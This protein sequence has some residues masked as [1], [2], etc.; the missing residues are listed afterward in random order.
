MLLAIETA[1]DVCS[2]A[3]LEGG[4]LVGVA[5]V[6]RPRSHASRLVP[7]VRDVLAQAEREVADL[8]AVAV[9]AGPGSFTGLRIGTSTAKGLAFVGG[10]ALV[11]VP[12]LEALALGAVDVLEA[13]DLLVAALPSRRGELYAAA[14]RA[15]G[16]ALS[17]A[18]PASA[19]ALEEL[20][21]WLP[22]SEG[23]LWVVGDAGRAAAEASGREARVLEPARFRASAALVGALGW[24]RWQAGQ[25]EELAAFEPAYL[26]AFVAKK[27]GSVFDRLPE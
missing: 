6:L 7:L 23:R 9:S 18:A 4:R 13:A 17:E 19:L 12:T 10:A 2:V 8:A 20:A 24:A 21:G 16:G 15:E 1:T 26:K 27:G 5:E 11:A 22:P 14:F 3:L 25:V